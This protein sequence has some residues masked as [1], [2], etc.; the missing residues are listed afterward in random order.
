M[1]QGS[2]P[3]WHHNWYAE[4]CWWGQNW[5]DKTIGR[6][7]LCFFCVL[8]FSNGHIPADWEE[9]FNLYL[10]EGKD[11][12]L[13]RGN[14]QGLKLTDQVMKLLE[15]VLEFYICIMVNMNDAQFGIMP[16]R[17]TTDTIYIVSQLQEKI[18]ASKL[19]YFA[20]VDP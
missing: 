19:P 2:W 5:A 15:L 1:R 9:R 4:S 12:A 16:G 20:F 6:F 7:F 3:I 18:A 11:E 17:G 14:Y 10:C 13:N 8:F